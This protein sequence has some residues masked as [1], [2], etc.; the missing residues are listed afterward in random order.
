MR[1]VVAA[2]Q[3]LAR[4][5]VGIVRKF[6]GNTAFGVYAPDVVCIRDSTNIPQIVYR[7]ER[8]GVPCAISDPA[9]NGFHPRDNDGAENLSVM[10]LKVF[11]EQKSGSS[12]YINNSLCIC[13][14]K[15]RIGWKYLY[16]RSTANVGIGL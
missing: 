8:P 12:C 15:F 6:T 10:E 7:G 3:S 11:K 5:V 14:C 2:V 4:P 9:R 16:D 1:F 13:C